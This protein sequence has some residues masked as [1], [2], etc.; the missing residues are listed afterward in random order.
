MIVAV[1]IALLPTA[2]GSWELFK[3]CEDPT[4]QLEAMGVQ[5][6]CIKLEGSYHLLEQQI[7]REGEYKF[8]HW[9]L[10][11]FSLV[12]TDEGGTVTFTMS[13]C[14]GVPQVFVKPALLYQGNAM[15]QLFETVP[16]SNGSRT[17]TWPFPDNNTGRVAQ[18]PDAFLVNGDYPGDVFEEIIWGFNGTSLGQGGRPDE[19]AITIDIQNA[20]YFISVY[21]VT[22]STFTMQVEARIGRPLGVTPY[23]CASPG[24]SDFNNIADCYNNPEYNKELEVP[25]ELMAQAASCDVA[26]TEEQCKDLCCLWEP[27]NATCSPTPRL[28]SVCA[29]QIVL[30]ESAKIEVHWKTSVDPNDEYRVYRVER[31]DCES[32]INSRGYKVVNP[33]CPNKKFEARSGVCGSGINEYEC[34]MWTPCGAK[35]IGEAMG[36]WRRETQNSWARRVYTDVSNNVPYFFNVLRRFRDAKGNLRY[37]AYAGANSTATYRRVYQA[38]SDTTILVIAGSAVMALLG[39]CA[40]VVAV[41]VR[42]S[43][44]LLNVYKKAS[45]HQKGKK[46]KKKGPTPEF[47]DGIMSG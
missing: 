6:E 46:K 27:V 12:N 36:E 1:F 43:R 47:S 9:T 10:D 24:D 15:E 25:V 26:F 40:C 45:A 19:H 29:N 2:R 38:Q 44:K 17:Q 37:E 31:P 11:D 23:R 20:G 8:Y 16:G 32:M 5:K 41:K 4:N 14:N 35:F 42:T 3:A 39:L 18:G 13:P 33:G 34:V 30:A 28:Q 7:V 21:G 22:N